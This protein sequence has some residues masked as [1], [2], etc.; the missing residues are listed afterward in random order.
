MDSAC[1]VDAISRLIYDRIG[2]RS[3]KRVRDRSGFQR[4]APGL[5]ALEVGRDVELADGTVLLE[6]VVDPGDLAPEK[7]ARR[8]AHLDGVVELVGERPGELER[9][10][11]DVEAEAIGAAAVPQLVVL[12]VPEIE[13]AA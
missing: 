6:G 2:P 3:S 1:D 7:L 11:E 12:R 9:A 10:Q 4:D 5:G 8:L 13:L